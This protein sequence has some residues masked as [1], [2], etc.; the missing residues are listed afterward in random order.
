[1]KGD[2]VFIDN[3]FGIDGYHTDK[4]MTYMSGAPVPDKA[5]EIHQQCVEIQDQIATLLKPGNTPSGIFT[6]IMDGLPPGFQENFMDFGDRQVQFLGHGVGLQVDEYPVNARG[7]DEPLE[8]GMVLAVE[9]KKGIPGVG[10]VG[11]ENTYI[12]TM[13]GGRCITGSSPGRIPVF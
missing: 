12:V 5:I 13:Q 3:A 8:E 10:M 4:T 1:M 2:L 7:F 9:P 6:T 11:T